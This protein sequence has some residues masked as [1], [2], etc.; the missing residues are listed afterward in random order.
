MRIHGLIASVVLAIA[1]CS[2]E[3]VPATA[4]VPPA[5]RQ[6]AKPPYVPPEQPE[7]FPIA[8]N[9]S[10]GNFAKIDRQVEKFVAARARDVDGRPKLFLLELDFEEHLGLPGTGTNADTH[11][12]LEA[13][14]QEFPD[15]AYR[16][17]VEAMIVSAS[18]WRAR[19]NGFSS[20]VTPEGWKL[21]HERTGDAWRILMENR[22]T[23]SRIPSWYAR[24]ISTGL[25]SGMS[26]SELRGLFDEGIARHPGY[27]PIYFSYLRNFAP[28]WGGSFREADKFILE[29]VSAPTNAD[30]EALYARLYWLLDQ[31]EGQD[32][33]LFEESAVSWPRMRKAFEALMKD[34]PDSEWNRAN[35]ASFACRAHDATA[36]G[37]L[38]SKVQEVSFWNAAPEGLSLDVCDARFL[39]PT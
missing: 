14:R 26:T 7:N 9:L 8:A 33:S 39:K 3:P 17:I 28:R 22:R 37:L 36:Y 30:G 10:M 27:L 11:R 5:Q 20:T 6:A 21:F 15:S 1:G 29:Q 23:S 24:A 35:F 18:A 19:G 2:R 38:R 31:V 4:A 25:D 34:Y 12:K 32:T 13:W 16:P